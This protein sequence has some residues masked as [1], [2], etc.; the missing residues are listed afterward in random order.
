[1]EGISANLLEQLNFRWKL[2]RIQS[3]LNVD[4]FVKCCY[5]M[6]WQSLHLWFGCMLGLGLWKLLFINW[7]VGCINLDGLSTMEGIPANL[8]EQLNFRWNALRIQSSTTLYYKVL[9]QY[10]SV[11]Q[12]TT[13]VLRRTTKCYSTSAT[14]V[15]LSAT[16]Y[17]SSTAVYYKVL[18]QY[19]SVLQ[20]TTPVLLCTTR[21]YSSTTLYYKIIL[22]YHSV[23]QSTTPVLLCT[24]KCYSSSATQVLLSTTKYYSSTTLYY[25][26][27]L[28]Y[29]KVLPQYYS[30]LQSTTPVL[31]C[32][33]E[34]SSSTAT[35]VLPYTTKYCSSTAKSYSS[36][37]QSVTPV[38]LCTT[39][40]YYYLPQQNAIPMVINYWLRT[41]SDW[42]FDYSSTTL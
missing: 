3:F 42:G 10:F 2:I 9:L 39:K 29:Y 41:V 11:L 18:L 31:L 24:T 15:L 27:L 23:L 6:F 28:L 17:Y 26:V 37:T 20:S 4:L 12:S 35:Q 8:L 22:Q 5:C 34:C 36:T 25:K 1:M 33:T 7:W 32:T 19:Y 40:C 21:Y 14:Q 13:P 38:L 16:K 30:V